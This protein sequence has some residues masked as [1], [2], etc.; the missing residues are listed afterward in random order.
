[1]TNSNPVSNALPEDTDSDIQKLLDAVTA[2]QSRGE[3][4]RFLT[5]LCTPS[6]L[7]ALVARWRVAQLLDEG[8]LSYRDISE[9][10]GASTTTVGRVARFL[11]EETY[12]GYRIALNR[13]AEQ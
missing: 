1:M 2:L 10:T 5:D 8:D 7:R 3:L 11:N 12:Q 9:K 6:E 4:L 13:V